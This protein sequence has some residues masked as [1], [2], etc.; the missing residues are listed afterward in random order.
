V[1]VREMP[2]R[3]LLEPLAGKYRK[4]PVMQVGADIFCDT[5]AI[6]SE[7]ARLSGKPE[8]A[9]ENCSEE[10]QAFVRRTDLDVFLAAVVSAPGP[11]LL[12]KLW[13]GSSLLN[14]ARFLKDRIS[15]ARGATVKAVGPKQAKQIVHA[16][17]EDLERRLEAQPFLFGDQPTI[18]DFSA[19]HSLWFI[20]DMGESSYTD[21][22]ERVTG[23]MGR[24][25]EFGHGTHR[26]ISAQEAQQMART[27]TPRV[28]AETGSSPLLGQ[29]VSIAP[30]D[31][32]QI[33]V[34]GILLA[35]LP[36]GWVLGREDKRVG[37]V[38]VHFPKQGFALGTP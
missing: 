17:L 2:P 1:E 22:F 16:Q 33:P 32:G 7:I 28:L 34:T 3:P 24:M 10:I 37:Q 9:L 36:H 4:I 38:Q 23:W 15:M 13:K 26:S 11:V 30:D 8:L 21:R 19:W 18:A 31:Y 29:T 5:R 20:H 12:R 35:D 27:S 25:R 6:T 14:V